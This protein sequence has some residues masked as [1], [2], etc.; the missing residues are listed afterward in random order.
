MILFIIRKNGEKVNRRLV[1]RQLYYYHR[2]ASSNSRII[3]IQLKRLHSNRIYIFIFIFSYLIY[4][5]FHLNVY[6]FH[7]D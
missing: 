5:I 1:S 2:L 6:V 7:F 3:V 4:L